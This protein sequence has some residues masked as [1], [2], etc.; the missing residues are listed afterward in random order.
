[1]LNNFSTK[2]FIA[3][4]TSY[5]VRKRVQDRKHMLKIS[6]VGTN[7]IRHRAVSVQEQETTI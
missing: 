2:G 1:V 5:L 4:V 3:R 7:E 6:T